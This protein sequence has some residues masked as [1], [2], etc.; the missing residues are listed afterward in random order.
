MNLRP[1]NIRTGRYHSDDDNYRSSIDKSNTGGNRHAVIELLSRILLLSMALLLVSCTQNLGSNLN[2]G[3]N[4]SPGIKKILVINTNRSLE[5]YSVSQASFIETINLAWESTLSI[6]TVDLHH[7]NAPI[8]TL[9]DML[10][11]HHYDAIYC[12]GAKALGA[13]DYID[14]ETPVIFS[15]VLNWRR[16]INQPNYYG[17][18]SEVPPEAQLTWFKHFFPAI[19]KVGVLYSANNRKLLKDA[20][21][22]ANKLSIQIIGEEVSSEANTLEQANAL[23]QKVD[24][25]WLV[26]DS[27]V[28]SSAESAQQLF[29][30]ANEHK[31]PV[32][33]YNPVFI[34]MGAVLS[35]A[36]DV[37]TTGRQAALITNS[38]LN[39][40]NEQTSVQYPAGSS[41]SLNMKKVLAYDLELNSNA[42]DSVNDIVGEGE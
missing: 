39:A 20:S 4:E 16:F 42:L 6:N 27:T 29:D 24:V 14:P 28:L 12:I 5:R 7:D 19:K 11:Q 13:I 32:F 40:R 31:T 8:D 41:I 30:A 22:A 21:Q 17:V 10:N 3:K 2:K 26:S 33:S 23:L 37:P 15:S 35:I 25:L 9:Q 1:N 34:E 36:A 18:A 38:L